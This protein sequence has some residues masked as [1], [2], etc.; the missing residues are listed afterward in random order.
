MVFEGDG[1]AVKRPDNL[2]MGAEVVVD[3]AGAIQGAVNEYLGEAVC[4]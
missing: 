2:A 3:L 1:E 4:L